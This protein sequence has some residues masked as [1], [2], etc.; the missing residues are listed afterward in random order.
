MASV[1]R[2]INLMTL[3]GTSCL[4]AKK[5]NVPCR[6]YETGAQRTMRRSLLVVLD[7]GEAKAK[8][9]GFC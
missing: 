3:I 1:T 4:F 9:C 8:K 2:H 7:V 6:N 5:S